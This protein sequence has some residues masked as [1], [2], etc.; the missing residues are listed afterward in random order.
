MMI[1]EETREPCYQWSNPFRTSTMSYSEYTRS[2]ACEERI[3]YYIVGL[4][5]AYQYNR[6]DHLAITP[7]YHKT[8]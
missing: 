6:E 2:I 7:K 8:N 4:V 5:S 3:N 1:Q